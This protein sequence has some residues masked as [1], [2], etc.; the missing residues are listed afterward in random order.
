[1]SK[2]IQSKYWCL[3]VFKD[4]EE[5]S[6]TLE[7]LHEEKVLSYAV[8]QEEVCP[9]TKREHLQAYIE[10]TN[11]K[12][13]N[14]VK[15]KFPGDH[16][17][18]RKS[19]SNQPAR[20]YCM[21]EDSRKQGC[22][23]V[24]IGTFVPQGQGKRN[25]IIALRDAVMSGQDYKQL[26]DDDCLVQAVARY[27]R[28]VDKL[29]NIARP[30]RNFMTRCHVFWGNTGSGKS[31]RAHWEA[32]QICDEPYV[33]DPASVW[34]DG[35]QG[36]SAVIIDDYRGNI[37]LAYMLRL[38][39][40]YPLRVQV[41]GG[42]VKFLA[43]DVWITSNVSPE[44]WWNKTQKGYNASWAAWNRR[45]TVEDFMHTN[46]GVWAPPPEEPDDDVDMK[47]IEEE[48]EDEDISYP[49]G[50]IPSDAETIVYDNQ[51]DVLQE[52][53]TSESDTF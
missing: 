30:N 39:D 23:P 12:S 7:G 29:Q 28:F 11:R 3:T 14:W 34:W 52:D 49:E 47:A 27:P 6:E 43:T 42:Y 38:I 1:M 41:K 2:R 19:R 46:N 53:V 5:L 50:D 36:E 4:A 51:F 15:D 37:P 32:G 40:R 9:E 8:F 18:R 10:L 48:D 45:I 21:K 22:E 24:E 33:K 16:I 17:E 31:R 44:D 13:F 26:V 20:D 25:D 35:Y